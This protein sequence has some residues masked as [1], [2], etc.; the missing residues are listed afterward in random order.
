MKTALPLMQHT[1]MK[2]T[3]NGSSGNQ[4]FQQ[5]NRLGYRS[6]RRPVHHPIHHPV[7]RAHKGLTL[8]ELMIAMVISIFLL[9]GV[10]QMFAASKQTYRLQDGLARLQ[11]NA[12]FSLDLIGGEMRLAGYMGCYASGSANMVNTLNVTD[13]EMQLDIAL[14][15]F[16][17]DGTN[18]TG[19]VGSV[20]TEVPEVI[21]NAIATIPADQ[22]SSDVLTIRRVADQGLRLASTM[23][24]VSA[25]LKAVDDTND[26][27][28]D[29]DILLISDCTRSAIFQTTNITVPGGGGNINIVHNTGICAPGNATKPLIEG[30]GEPFSTDASI[31]KM[32]TTTF[33]IAPS[34]I[35]NAEGD[36]VLSLWRKEFNNAPQELVAGVESMQFLYGIDSGTDGIP[37]Y[38]A[39]A[40]AQ[41]LSTAVSIRIDL[42]LNTIDRATLNGDGLVRRTFGQTIQIRNQ[43]NN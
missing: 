43:L 13:Y 8:I 3:L 10:I 29:C 38:Y 36:T 15:S 34:D 20:W 32:A 9:A 14:S 37:N 5:P 26:P 31:Y 25:D 11:E 7:H 35:D 30:S 33:F 42:V 18:Y 27:P 40:G 17:S 41:D 4:P 21:R 22:P 6:M 1:T 24:N 12:R 39:R 2:N 16:E 28:E 23:P 19:S